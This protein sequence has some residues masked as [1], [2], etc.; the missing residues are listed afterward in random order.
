MISTPVMIRAAL[1]VTFG[2]TLL[3]LAA[4]NF[5]LAEMSAAA[6]GARFDWILLGMGLYALDVLVRIER[7]RR[8]IQPTLQLRYPAVAEALLV[9]YAMNNLLPARLGE[10]F[11][12]DFISRRHNLARSAAVGSI[13]I[14]RMMDVLMVV[15]IFVLGLVAVSAA[16]A[17]ALR[18]LVIVA[19]LAIVGLVGGALTIA[20][21]VK[22]HSRLPDRF[23][24]INA[25]VAMLAGSISALT[26]TDFRRLLFLSAVIWLFEAAA[27]G[28]MVLAFGVDLDLA[29]LCVL[30]GA[31]SLSALLPSAPGYLGS[32]QIAFVAAF[33]AIGAAEPLGLLSATA[34]QIFLLG[35]VSIIGVT[36]LV[37]S[38]FYTSRDAYAHRDPVTSL[39]STHQIAR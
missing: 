24:W 2:L 20:A 32:L 26:S 22:W 15:G 31:C 38:R 16:S 17:P 25:R 39:S 18:T 36:I 19:V 11:R 5:D 27:I 37:A 34:T 13:M 29:G 12:A 8:L 1:G 7:W 9:G 30:V 28:C 35:S 23:A 14:E 33:S 4:R 6:R 21:V 10:L 3:Y